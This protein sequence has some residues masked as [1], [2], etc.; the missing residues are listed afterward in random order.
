MENGEVVN[1]LIRINL[2]QSNYSAFKWKE[3]VFQTN[4]YK[5]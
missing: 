2:T 3:I 4:N 1:D 5:T